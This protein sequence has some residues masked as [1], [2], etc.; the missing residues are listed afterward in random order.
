MKPGLSPEEFVRRQRLRMRGTWAAWAVALL[1]GAAACAADPLLGS[2]LRSGLTLA[3]AGGG[4]G[5]LLLWLLFRARLDERAIACQCDRRWSLQGRLETVVELRADGSALARAQ[6]AEAAERIRSLRPEGT[7]FWTAGITLAAA[8]LALAAYERVTYR[9][10]AAA[11]HARG[12]VPAAGSI[13]WIAPA[14]F[15]QVS[16]L[17]DVPLRARLAANRPLKSVTLTETLDGSPAATIAIALGPS[18]AGGEADISSVLHL[19]D[20]GSKPFDL[21]SYWLQAQLPDERGGRSLVSPRQRVDVRPAGALP[22]SASAVLGR[23]LLRRLDGLRQGQQDLIDRTADQ[24]GRTDP[25][26]VAAGADLLRRGREIR[27]VAAGMRLPAGVLRKLDVANADVARAASE[28]GGVGAGA[29]PEAESHALAQMADAERAVY[30]ALAARESA[31]APAYASA[32]RSSTSARRPSPRSALATLS[33][34]L[35]DFRQPEKMG[36]NAE[37]SFEREERAVAAAAHALADDHRLSDA[38]RARVADARGAASD[39]ARQ[40]ELGDQAAAQSAA[41]QSLAALADAQRI[42]DEDAKREADAVLQQTRQD[43]VAA[44]VD[45]SPADAAAQIA[46]AQQALRYE[47]DRQAEEGSAG[48]AQM[49]AKLAHQLASEADSAPSP[50]SI[51]SFDA[52]SGNDGA[53]TASDPDAKYGLGATGGNPKNSRPQTSGQNVAAGHSRPKPGSSPSLSGAPPWS[54]G[55]AAASGSGSAQEASSP[56][57]DSS[58]GSLSSTQSADATQ[59]SA[60]SSSP[61]RGSASTRQSSGESQGST[62]SPQSGGETAQGGTQ[63]SGQSSASREPPNAQG[64]SS[65]KASGSPS[66]GSSEQSHSAG[67]SSASGGSQ[68][69]VSSSP[70]SSSGG[71]SAPSPSSATG[72][73]GSSQLPSQAGQ[74]SGGASGSSNS[75]SPDS[76]SGSGS[77]GSSGAAPAGSQSSTSSGSTSSS[78]SGQGGILGSS[79]SSRQSASSSPGTPGS[80]GSGN[81]GQ[82]RSAESSTASRQSSQGSSG[83]SSSSSAPGAKGTPPSGAGQSGNHPSAKGGKLSNGSAGGAS[84]GTSSASKTPS[85]QT[86]KSGAFGGSAGASFARDGSPSQANPAPPPN[87]AAA[88]AESIAQTQVQFDPAEANQR[89]VRTLQNFAQW[90]D[91]EASPG[92]PSNIDALTWRAGPRYIVMLEGAARQVTYLTPDDRAR[93]LARKILN[94]LQSADYRSPAIAAAQVRLLATDA[95]QLAQILEAERPAGARNEWLR[96]VAPDDIDPKYRRAIDKY[97]ESLSRESVS[98]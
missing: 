70:S 55:T 82:S 58:P 12:E 14:A 94:R 21:V 83:A 78:T 23:S 34:A 3:L 28:L 92:F 36:A 98:P 53:G 20:I 19:A 59:P 68:P 16:S 38:A 39:A 31:A 30:G 97:F 4:A 37:A 56:S 63:E 35:D 45:P 81:S 89:T 49:L 9:A 85:G 71:S 5:L 72:S 47:S 43:L 60:A 87:A 67:S 75:G 50:D 62:G 8:A 1:G 51:T 46:Q 26:L 48:T 25:A 80:S 44:S 61:S 57:A 24:A 95:R 77:A 15:L 17:E 33:S 27:A 91:G 79:P 11:A 93:A 6:R 76:A 54:D 88:A 41:A 86:F 64:T 73:Q 74:A 65:Q 90:G 42:L 32:G 96:G 22:L 2:A 52:G 40:A 18:F 84:Q 29:T 7:L 13:V 69:P 10:H 66:S